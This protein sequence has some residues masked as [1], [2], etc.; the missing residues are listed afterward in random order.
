MR[1]RVSDRPLHKFLNIVCERMIT[2]QEIVQFT[3]RR[4]ESLD[5]SRPGKRSG[6]HL[7]EFAAQKTLRTEQQIADV[8]EYLKWRSRIIGRSEIAELRRCAFD[9]YSPTKD[10]GCH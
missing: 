10:N 2:G 5:L 1:E 8:R 9:R 6:D 3:S 7:D 4:E